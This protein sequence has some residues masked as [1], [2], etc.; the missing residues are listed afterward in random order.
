MTARAWKGEREGHDAVENTAPLVVEFR[1]DAETSG[2]TVTMPSVPQLVT[3]GKTLKDAHSRVRLALAALG[4][5]EGAASVRLQG[6]VIW[7]DRPDLSDEAM[8][9]ISQESELR[10]RS[11]DLQVELER[12][13]KEAVRVLIERD[14]LTYRSAGVLLGIT[15]QRVEQIAKQEPV[16]GG[17]ELNTA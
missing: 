10:V 15:H 13:T 6:F 7:A 17:D 9:W 3:Q 5:G 14:H 8:K 1:Q 2:W 12:V 16:S 4:E 11:L